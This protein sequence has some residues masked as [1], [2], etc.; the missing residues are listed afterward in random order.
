MSHTPGPW[1]AEYTVGSVL[2]N[3]WTI[4][5][6]AGRQVCSPTIYTREDACLIAAAPELLEVAMKAL[7]GET[8]CGGALAEE[9]KA[10]ITKAR[11]EV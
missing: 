8:I 11:G 3:H 4:V 5:D 9:L 2:G 1:T 10:A 6:S 7:H